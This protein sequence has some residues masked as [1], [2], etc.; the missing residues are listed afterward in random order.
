MS[1]GMRKRI[2]LLRVA[3]LAKDLQILQLLYDI[4]KNSL[5]CSSELLQFMSKIDEDGSNIYSVT[6]L[7]AKS[8]LFEF[9]HKE[10]E[11]IATFEEIRKML[12]STDIWKR[13]LFQTAVNQNTF[14]VLHESLWKVI[15]KYFNSAEILQ[16][17]KHIEAFDKN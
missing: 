12:S 3:G 9:I 16:F 8:D 10:L 17:I 1:E 4:V 7:F 5:E 14:T 11:K 2:M 13:N 15:R 6:G